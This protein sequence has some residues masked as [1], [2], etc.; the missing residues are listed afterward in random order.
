MPLAKMIYSSKMR[1]RHYCG[2]DVLNAPVPDAL[3]RVST[4]PID[5]IVGDIADVVTFQDI[6]LPAAPSLIV[7]F[8]M[9]EHV[10]HE[11]AIRCLQAMRR[12]AGVAT[13]LI[14]STPC[15]DGKHCAKSHV[16]E[17]TYEAFGAM[18]EDAGWAIIANYGTFASIRDY[19]HLLTD[20]QKEVFNQL[21][22]YYDT[23]MLSTIFA[24]MFPAQ[25][26]NCLWYCDTSP[27]CPRRFKPLVDIPHPWGSAD[28][29]S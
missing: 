19:K 5:R 10:E 25:S 18:L 27:D 17:L 13:E 2:I 8:E 12:L 28:T 9:M 14:I 7:C 22:P 21:R 11:H 1:S 29:S 24:P 16:N 20:G 23:N 6:D 4:F 15:W 26:R 3:R